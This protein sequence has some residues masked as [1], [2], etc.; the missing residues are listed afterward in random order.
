MAGATTH[1]GPKMYTVHQHKKFEYF[2]NYDI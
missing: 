2:K 1:E